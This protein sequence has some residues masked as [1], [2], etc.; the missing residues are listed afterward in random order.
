[1]PPKKKS[2]HIGQL[3]PEVGISAEQRKAM[4]VLNGDYDD[5]PGEYVTACETA[6][7]VSS[8]IRSAIAADYL[9]FGTQVRVL[10][11]R[12]VIIDQRVR[13]RIET[14]PGWITIFDAKHRF[15]LV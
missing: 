15:R 9:E 14:P 3:L 10:E 1:M 13:G 4:S 8:S 2:R 7:R 11:I 5:Q 6:V 12:H